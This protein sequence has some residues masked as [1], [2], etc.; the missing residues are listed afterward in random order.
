MFDLRN[1]YSKE[2][3]EKENVLNTFLWGDNRDEKI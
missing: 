2:I 3:I 1:I